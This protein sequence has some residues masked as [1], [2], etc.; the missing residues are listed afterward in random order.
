MA[1]N[2]VKKPSKVK[3]FFKGVK[4]EFK[5]IVWPSFHTVVNNTGVVIAVS[6]IVAVIVYLLD[7][8]FG[9]GASKILSL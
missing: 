5:K 6:I 8:G 7:L 1:E 3:E 4:G 9:F 2:K